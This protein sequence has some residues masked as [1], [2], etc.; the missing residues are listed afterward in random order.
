MRGHTHNLDIADDLVLET[1]TLIKYGNFKSALELLPSNQ[2]AIVEKLSVTR[3]L[4]RCIHDYDV[5]WTCRL[6]WDSLSHWNLSI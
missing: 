5:S 3:G 6:S 1:Q 4:L 2:R